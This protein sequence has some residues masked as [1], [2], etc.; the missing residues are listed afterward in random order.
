MNYQ[1]QFSQKKVWLDVAIIGGFLGNYGWRW[2][3]LKV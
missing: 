1:G 2:A 3:L